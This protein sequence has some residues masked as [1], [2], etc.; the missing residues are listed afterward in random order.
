MSESPMTPA[1]IRD[2]FDRLGR[3]YEEFKSVNERRITELERHGR[4]DPV[5]VDRLDKVETAVAGLSET[6]ERQTLTQRRPPASAEGR[7]L[8]PAEIE[9]KQAFLGFLRKGIDVGLPEMER[10]ALSIGSDPDGGYLVPADMSGRIVAR[11]FDTSPIRAIANVIVIST[12]VLE[13]LRDTD[14]AGAGWVAETGARAETTTPQLGKW[15]VPVHEMYAEPRA[16]QSLLDDS[17]VDVEAWIESKIAERFTRLESTAFVTGDGVNKPRGFTT[18]PTAATADGTRPWGTLEHLVTGVNG[19]FAASNPADKLFDVVQAFKP[20]Y[21]AGA[22][23][24]TRRTVLAKIRKFRDGQ[25][26]YLWQ[27]GLQQGHPSTLLGY[28]VVLAE[29]MPA[30][31]AGS[32]SLALGNFREAYQI[33]DRIGIRVLRDPYTAKPYVKFYTTRRVGGDV[34][35]SEA[36]KLLKF[37]T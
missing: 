23:W 36:I 4:A 3:A 10:K 24:V 30:L 21:L 28:P 6:L 32:L 8:K 33:V 1:E 16:T 34:V 9:H 19:D 14:E 31:G 11:V 35:Q 15:R 5:T 18:L 13:G 29:D 27:P 17:A 2:G 37:S 26:Q 20:Q 7:P 22:V 12:E 25:G